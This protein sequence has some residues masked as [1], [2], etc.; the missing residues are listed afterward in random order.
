M[1]RPDSGWTGQPIGKTGK[2]GY[3]STEWRAADSSAERTEMARQLRKAAKERG[4]GD[5]A[6][7]CKHRFE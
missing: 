1:D 4:S 7:G 3:A 6:A 2:V 5:R